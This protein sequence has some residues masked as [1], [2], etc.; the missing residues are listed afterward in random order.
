MKTPAAAGP[1]IILFAHGARDERWAEPFARI[2]SKVRAAAPGVLIELAYLEHLEPSLEQAARRL[3][4]LGA[5][6]IRVVPLFLGR[7]GHLRVDVPRLI[8]AAEA[9]GRRD[10]IGAVRGRGRRSDRCS[11]GLLCA[12]RARTRPALA[13]NDRIDRDASGR[14]A[15]PRFAR[16]PQ[17]VPGRDRERWHRSRGHARR[18][19]RGARRERS[20][21]VDADEGDPRGDTADCRRNVVGGQAGA[22]P[23]SGARPRARHRDGLSAFLAVRDLD[24][25]RE[26]RADASARIRS[27]HA[28]S[29]NH[30][31]VH[32]IRAPR[33]SAPA[34]A[35]AIGRRAPAG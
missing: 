26:H 29:G 1:A 10:R 17:S 6:T 3:A 18:N 21:Q 33:R 20:R 24:R 30:R 4:K 2:V 25:H 34:R 27:R 35:R 28:R 32:A 31:G 14:G 7:G 12:R 5:T 9:D 8:G 11:G 22:A 16:H 19:P 23:G 15:A 13:L